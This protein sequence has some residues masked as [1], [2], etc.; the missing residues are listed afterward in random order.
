MVAKLH[1]G[2]NIW[3]DPSVGIPCH[4]PMAVSYYGKCILLRGGRWRKWSL[5][6]AS[7]RGGLLAPPELRLFIFKTMVLK[8]IALNFSPVQIFYASV[9]ENSEVTWPES[10]QLLQT[11]LLQIL[12]SLVYIPSHW[13]L[14]TLCSLLILSW[15]STQ[16]L[17]VSLNTFFVL[18]FLS[19]ILNYDLF[20]A[21]VPGS[22][23]C[24]TGLT[25]LFGVPVTLRATP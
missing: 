18:H 17:T 10:G 3:P 16:I 22:F 25:Q 8:N 23:P 12:G 19:S 6:F 7:L 5:R 2:T 9:T 21:Y 1:F 13:P 11:Q 14:L 20:L 15:P 24:L 4:G